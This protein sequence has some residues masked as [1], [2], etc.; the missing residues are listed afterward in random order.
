MSGDQTSCVVEGGSDPT[1]GSSPPGRSSQLVVLDWG[2]GMEKAFDGYNSRCCGIQNAEIQNAEMPVA[3]EKWRRRVR[4]VSLKGLVG[5][6]ARHP[7]TNKR[8]KATASS[9][10][11]RAHILVCFPESQVKVLCDARS[12]TIPYMCVCALAP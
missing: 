9:L 10:A 1:A 8:G 2:C 3:I 6:R 12:K 5:V 7:T 4:E 11:N